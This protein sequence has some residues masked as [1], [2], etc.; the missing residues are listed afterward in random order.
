MPQ[1]TNFDQTLLNLFSND[2]F[3]IALKIMLA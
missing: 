1:N 2:I 3:N